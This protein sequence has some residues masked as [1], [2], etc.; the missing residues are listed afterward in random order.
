MPFFPRGGPLFLPFDGE[1]DEEGKREEEE[2]PFLKR[3]STFIFPG[4]LPILHFLPPLPP[5]FQLLYIFQRKLCYCKRVPCPIH[6]AT[7]RREEYSS[8]KRT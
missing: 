1:E 7:A 5:P 6:A 3:P 4:R 2:V 8:Q